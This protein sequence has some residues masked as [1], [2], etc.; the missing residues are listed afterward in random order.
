MA[1]TKNLSKK[2]MAKMMEAEKKEVDAG[3]PFPE[4]QETPDPEIVQEEE[5]IIPTAKTQNPE[6]ISFIDLEVKPVKEEPQI[7][8]GVAFIEEKE[9]CSECGGEP[10][11]HECITCGK[12][13]CPEHEPL[14]YHHDG[15][16][17]CSEAPPTPKMIE[18]EAKKGNKIAILT[19]EATFEG[20]IDQQK[21]D[22]KKAKL[23]VKKQEEV[24]A[25][26]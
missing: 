8:E 21:Q 15:C 18:D 4:M 12:K 6:K 13:D 17:V 16:P 20:L 19:G 9:I 22:I 5:L 11:F 7:E 24:K 26:N 10:V 1:K 14:H 2:E 23:K 25:K 3:N